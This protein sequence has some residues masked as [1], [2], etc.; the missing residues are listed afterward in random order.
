M[1]PFS[2]NTRF[3][4]LRREQREAGDPTPEVAAG[5]SQ[6]ADTEEKV[7]VLARELDRLKRAIAV[8]EDKEL[9]SVYGMGPAAS[10]VYLRDRGL[11]IGG[12]VRVLHGV[13][14][15]KARREA[16]NEEVG[17]VSTADLVDEA[18]RVQKANRRLATIG[19][20]TYL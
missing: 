1:E 8:P 12:W 13:L 20:G 17:P 15:R 14:R 9:T 7:N 5:P 10:K 3:G 6:D 2:T 4:C 16:A 19:N 18:A 11:S